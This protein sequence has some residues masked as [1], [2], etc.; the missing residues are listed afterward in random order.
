MSFYFPPFVRLAFFIPSLI[1]SILVLSSCGAGDD[2]KQHIPNTPLLNSL[3]V[4]GY[5]I[6]FEQNKLS[7][8][9]LD[10]SKEVSLI[11][12]NAVANRD[13]IAITLKITNEQRSDIIECDNKVEGDIE[14]E[15]GDNLIQLVLSDTE[16][17]VAYVLKVH[18]VRTSAS[19]S[20]L[21]IYDF[22][23]TGENISISPSFA[24]NEF[25]YE[26]NVPYYTCS[27]S[28]VVTPTHRETTM[29]I[30][31]DKISSNEVSYHSLHVGENS[32]V[33]EAIS[34]NG[35]FSE[36]YTVFINRE[37]PSDAQLSLFAGIQEIEFQELDFN[38]ICGIYDY[39]IILNK[40]VTEIPLKI[41]PSIEGARVYIDGNEIF[42]DDWYRIPVDN[43][44]GVIQ[45]T[46]LSLNEESQRA[47]SISY[48]RYARNIVSVSTA[49]E[50]QY[51]LMNAEP[52]D[53]I[54]LAEGTYNTDASPLEGGVDATHFF[55]DRSGTPNERIYLIADDEDVVMSGTNTSNARVLTL[56]GN[57]WDINGIQFSNARKGIVADNAHHN[58]FRN[59][60]LTE[61]GESGISLINGSQNNTISL[62]SFSRM[63]SLETDGPLVDV[64]HSAV[65]VGD[66]RTEDENSGGA[67]ELDNGIRHNTFL[68]LGGAA[69]IYLGG[70]AKDT[71]IEY[72]AFV[73]EKV[74]SENARDA[75]V[76]NQGVNTTIRYNNVKHD[77]PNALNTVI[78][79]DSALTDNAELAVNAIIYQN[80]FDLNSR[81][82]PIASADNN[83]VITAFENFRDDQVEAYFH[84]VDVIDN[85]HVVPIYQI[86]LKQD[87]SKCLGVEYAESSNS[88]E[89]YYV[90]ILTSCS[91]MQ[92][93]QWKFLVDSGPYVSVINLAL[94][95]D[96]YLQTVSSY[97]GGCS[98]GESLVYLDEDIKSYSQRWMI[99]EVG[100]AIYLRSKKNRS[101]TLSVPGNTLSMGVPLSV[102]AL[103]NKDNQQFQLIN[104]N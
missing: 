38:F 3:V 83:A 89:G 51:A 56:K 72:N 8:Y 46:T 66:N 77:I 45:I 86:Q 13:D 65:V 59:L 17:Q 31:G 40:S 85:D 60:Q 33:V 29:T 87:V 98:V 41:T 34:E 73:E 104:V 80:V 15:E 91:E 79:L 49:E 99:D 43:D 22:A 48:A 7:L 76:V 14:I 5:D 1:V 61:L 69:A 93:T 42:N 90:A 25:S 53:E 97:S 81:D 35:E 96:N 50:L 20:S 95:E 37:Q 23:G 67:T 103:E 32:L 36:A 92:Y 54:H 62:N 27:I 10:L 101:Y 64:I 21:A 47:Y 84:G 88:N 44:S 74:R 94:D 75:L 70:T 82:I 19:L 78:Q 52:N 71:Q 24:N 102:C 11:H 39:A 57:Y 6:E 58:V 100:G 4:A 12:L 2:T 28:S 30:N 16:A 9:E 55:S 26:V 63:S 68:S 18:K